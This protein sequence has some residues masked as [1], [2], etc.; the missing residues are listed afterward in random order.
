MKNVILNN[1]TVNDSHSQ[2]ATLN[3]QSAHLAPTRL[4][5]MKEKLFKQNS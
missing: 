4:R 5:P 1:K 2:S 3:Q